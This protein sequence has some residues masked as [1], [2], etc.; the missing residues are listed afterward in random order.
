[1]AIISQFQWNI[2]QV[3][4]GIKVNTIEVAVYA[5]GIMLGSYYGS[6]SAAISGLFLPRA[7][8]MV[9][10]N[11]NKELTDMMI[12][13][14]RISLIPLMLVLTAFI[15]FGREFVFLWLGNQYEN[16]YWI[17]LLIM[18]AYTI[19]LLQT[20]ANSIVEA[21]NK[22]AYKVKVYSISLTCGIVLGYFLITKYGGV[23][24]I[25]GIVIGWIIAQ[26]FMNFLFYSYFKLDIKRFFKQTFQSFI[27]P[28]I[29]SY[30]IGIFISKI[31]GNTWTDF[32]IKCVLYSLVYVLLVWN[33][34]LN[35]TEKKLFKLPGHNKL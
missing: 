3:I 34:A 15:L 27:I 4:L 26:I 33:V 18:I 1:M 8:Q 10:N 7:S 17:A 21:K 30:L 2:G 25:I 23:G 29:I 13:V 22:V 16:S 31:F 11:T 24:M 9:I 5:V 14:G 28:I 32:V 35:K 20:F 19:P 12:N 6:F